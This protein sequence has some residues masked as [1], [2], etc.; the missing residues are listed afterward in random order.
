MNKG[1]I[2][3]IVAAVV[4]VAAVAVYLWP[5][6]ENCP[7][8]SDTNPV[9]KTTYEQGDYFVFSS[10]SV[11]DGVKSEPVEYFKCVVGD[12]L[13]GGDRN[14][15][16]S[17]SLWGDQLDWGTITTFHHYIS[18]ADLEVKTYDKYDV[19]GETTLDTAFGKVKVTIYDGYSRLYYVDP[20]INVLYLVEYKTEPGEKQNFIELTGSNILI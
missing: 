19:V 11:I 5:D 15:I 8:E 6:D 7:P 17:G 9:F 18:S 3:G 20:A 16:I 2:I 13:G 1:L 12:D 10:Y 14:I 4:V